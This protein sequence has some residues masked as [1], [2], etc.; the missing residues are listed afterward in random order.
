LEGNAE[1]YFSTQPRSTCI[2]D[3]G[4]GVVAEGGSVNHTYSV[5][6]TYTVTLTYL[7]DEMQ[8]IRQMRFEVTV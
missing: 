3:F 8:I 5:P 2:W 1:F 6:G 4:D 7:N